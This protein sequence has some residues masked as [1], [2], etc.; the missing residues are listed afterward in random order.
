MKRSIA[1]LLAVL[2]VFSFAGNVFADDATCK[3]CKCP[4]WNVPCPEAVGEQEEPSL[5][6]PFDYETTTGYCAQPDNTRNCK[7][8]LDVCSCPDAC[9]IR[10]GNVL[11]VKMEI[12]TP[13]VYWAENAASVRFGM[14]PKTNVQ[15]AC[16][17]ET[18]GDNVPARD[19]RSIGGIQ[20]FKAGGTVAA[21]PNPACR[22][23]VADAEKAKI[24][25]SNDVTLGYVLTQQDTADNLC[26]MWIDIP[27]MIINAAEFTEAWRGQDIKI[28]VGIF[29]DWTWVENAD[30]YLCPDCVQ[31]KLCE[32]TITVAK[33]CCEPV[34][35][36]FSMLFPYFAPDT[37]ASYFWNGLVINNLDSKAGKADLLF[38]EADGDVGK[39]TITVPANGIYNSLLRNISGITVTKQGTGDTANAIGNSKAYIKV[40]TDFNVDGFAMLSDQAANGESMGYLPRI[41]DDAPACP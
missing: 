11:G 19:T 16:N 34:A 4:V 25:L 12:V 38:Y 29:T 31:P 35:N 10:V 26:Q 27:Q 33:F 1:S 14:F 24:L 21:T 22:N 8:I 2:M 6:C 37:D 30:D 13:G 5:M 32:C 7:V 18:I 41:G 40:C 36:N 28:K 20:Y 3:N 23:T 39:A 9:K 17:D 15:A